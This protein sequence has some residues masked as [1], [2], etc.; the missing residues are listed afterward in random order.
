MEQGSRVGVSCAGAARRASRLWS[1]ATP[2][3]VDQQRR[4]RSAIAKLEGANSEQTTVKPDA[5]NCKTAK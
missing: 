4:A 5:A 3:S 1:P 2:Q